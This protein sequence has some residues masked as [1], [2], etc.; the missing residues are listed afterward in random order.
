MRYQPGRT[1]GRTHGRT[2]GP[3]STIPHELVQWGIKMI[4]V[5]IVYFLAHSQYQFIA[6]VC[7]QKNRKNH[8]KGINTARNF[9][10]VR[11]K[12]FYIQLYIYMRS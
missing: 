5:I 10:L 8:K 12:K 4:L 11:N 1:D 7:C 3:H 2:D 9:E 6:V